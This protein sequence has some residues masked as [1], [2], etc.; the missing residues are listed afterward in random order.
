MLTAAIYN[1]DHE[2]HITNEI[3]TQMDDYSATVTEMRTSTDPGESGSESQP[4]SLAGELERLR[5]RLK[6]LNQSLDGG[7]SHWYQTAPDAALAVQVFS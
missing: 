6:E 3:P 5:F 4:T 1:A 7:L 2:N